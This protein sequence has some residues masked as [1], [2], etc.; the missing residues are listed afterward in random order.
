MATKCK[1]VRF[2]EEKIR[3]LEDRIERLK[4]TIQKI[5]VGDASACA[6]VACP[7]HSKKRER[8]FK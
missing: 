6:Q 8:I 7:V 4:A 5:E 1:Q 2:N 3:E